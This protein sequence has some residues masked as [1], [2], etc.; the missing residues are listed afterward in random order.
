[1]TKKAIFGLPFLFAYIVYK[2]HMA[3]IKR[4]DHRL[5]Q[6]FP[7]RANLINQ[8]IRVLL[9]FSLSIF[10]PFRTPTASSDYNRI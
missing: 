5:L 1:M 8:L 9:I 6:Q 4:I 3:Q 2:F 7:I 10:Q